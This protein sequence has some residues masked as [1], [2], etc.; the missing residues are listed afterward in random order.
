MH[1][2]V[3]WRELLGWNKEGT[4]TSH[5]VVMLFPTK[6]IKLFSRVMG[7]ATLQVVEGIGVPRIL[8]KC[9]DWFPLANVDRTFLFTGTF[10]HN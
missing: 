5:L 3:S 10:I 4:D 1:G 2:H 8:E 6:L 7:I 9:D